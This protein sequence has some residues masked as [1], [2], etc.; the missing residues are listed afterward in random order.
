[1]EP[2]SVDELRRIVEAGAN[3]ELADFIQTGHDVLETHLANMTALSETTL[4]LI[5]KYLCAHFYCVSNPQLTSES[6]VGVSGSRHMPALGTGFN[7]T[8]FGQTAIL[9]DTTG[10]LA[11]ISGKRLVFET[12]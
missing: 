6:G 9:L 12:V 2:T 5:Q 8:T 3:E 1:M 10:T 11:A 4:L 7:S